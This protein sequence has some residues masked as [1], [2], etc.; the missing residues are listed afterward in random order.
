MQQR[1]LPTPGRAR[2]PVARVPRVTARG[3]AALILSSMVVL[4][5]AFVGCVAVGFATASA[6]F[7]AILM[8]LALAMCLAT[9]YFVIFDANTSPVLM[10]VLL[11]LILFFELPGFIHILT[12]KFPFF[13][14]SYL[15]ADIDRA[16]LIVA[17]FCFALIASFM[18]RRF[19]A[20][21][22]RRRTRVAVS[23]TQKSVWVVA[24]AVLSI[25]AIASALSVGY[26]PSLTR[27]QQLE[28]QNSPTRLIGESVAQVGSFIA[29]MIAVL[30]QKQFKRDA[31][32]RIFLLATLATFLYHNNVVVLPRYVV[33]S[34]VLTFIFA[35]FDL[36][37]LRRGGL[38]AGMLVAQITVFPL[39][40]D[41]SR[42]GGASAFEFSPF[43]YLSTHGDFDGFQSVVNIV[44]WTQGATLKGGVQL[45][46]AVLFFVPREFVPW[47]SAGTGSDA[48]KYVGYP[49]TNISAP[50]PAELYVDFGMIGLVVMTVGLGW[51][52]HRLDD[53]FKEDKRRGGLGVLLTAVTAGYAFILLRGALIAVLG[54]FIVSIALVWLAERFVGRRQ[55]RRYAT[56]AGRDP[57]RRHAA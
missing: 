12:N 28:L 37:K 39:L 27:G 5:V 2:P 14:V 52:I 24:G 35:V 29:F 20:P 15:Q 36:S 19:A 16:A 11:Y 41:I 13:D 56:T 48:A 42:G 44:V 26:D 31:F 46:S 25:A 38:F 3:D 18:L 50:L 45:L 49:F 55:R 30:Y 51:F 9:L 34:Y 33:G 47:K 4:G 10:S 32:A 21:R 1:R 54:P 22:L 57:A 17:V 23:Y 6:T 7:G 40:S 43:R 53:G 8:S